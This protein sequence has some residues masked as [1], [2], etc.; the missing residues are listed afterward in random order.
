MPESE[1]M[2]KR[3][4]AIVLLGGILWWSNHADGGAARLGLHPSAA[5]FS[6]RLEGG[7]SSGPAALEPWFQVEHSIDLRTWKPVGELSNRVAGNHALEV[8]PAHS[9]H[10]FYRVIRR[11]PVLTGRDLAGLDFSG[12]VMENL[13]L[14]G[15]DLRYADFSGARLGGANLSGADLRGAD[16]RFTDLSKADLNGARFAGANLVGAVLPDQKGELVGLEE[17]LQI[18]FDSPWGGPIPMPSE[19]PISVG[20]PALPP[21]PTSP[22]LPPVALPAPVPLPGAM[23]G[24]P[25]ADALARENL[26]FA[27]GGA[28]DVGN[29]RENIEN[30]FLPL[31]T[32][33]T[34]EGL[35]YDYFFET[36]LNAPCDSLFCPSYTQAVSLDPFSKRV[37]RY[38]AVGLNSGIKASDFARKQ[39]NLT[40]VLDVSGSMNAPFN[41]FYYDRSG[42]QQELEGE[43][44]NLLKMDVAI[45]AVTA[46]MDHLQPEDRIGIVT[47]N[48]ESRV[49]QAL[50]KVANLDL[51]AVRQKVIRLRA[52]SGTNMSAGMRSAT[53]Q[54][55]ALMEADPAVSENR[56]IF[57]TDAMPNQGETTRSGLFG[58]IERNAAK[59]LYSTVIGVGVDFNTN[60]IENI[61][62]NRGAN[63][64]S[65]HSPAQFIEQMD[66]NFDFMVTPLVF[67]LRLSL[68]GDGWSIDRVYGSPEAD[69]ATGEI[70]RVNTLFPS[71][72]EEGE[73]RGGLMLIKL[74]RNP[75]AE[76]QTLTLAAQYENRVGETFS[77]ES[78]I[79]LRSPDAVHHDNRGIR[80]GILLTRFAN[81]M[82]EWILDERMSYHDERPIL[83]P[84]I[85]PEWGI[86]IPPPWPDVSLGQ[87]ERRS[88]ALYVSP[89][90]RQR[91]TQFA[92]HVAAEMGEIGDETL[93]QELDVLKRLTRR[94]FLEDAVE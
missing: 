76:N 18:D 94:P 69:E 73:T 92:E 5:G 54:Y 24:A 81:L 45:E 61:T 11:A 19:V 72:S 49:V 64:H 50:T 41:R 1:G 84:L 55:D 29:F 35:F 86:P 85:L 22:G 42:V 53:R 89:K 3:G 31:F 91:M 71:K 30:D 2:M 52:F 28:N 70:V 21:V 12:Q 6:L 48:S 63:Y 34:Y 60:L 36:G 7:T 14:S 23:F 75:G 74:S 25:A 79:E 10:G 39:L 16:L 44:R 17:A 9:E 83:R 38:L 20:A 27:V 82:K 4:R 57:V 68:R 46:L 66:E 58:M 26:G 32:D 77:I 62:K 87:W 40:I 80:K 93:Q 15:A 47:F 65:V 8:N 59:K 43:E 13:D 67:D 78:E 51:D 88:M 37:E 90:Y 56:I 33:I